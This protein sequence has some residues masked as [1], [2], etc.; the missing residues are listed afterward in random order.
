MERISDASWSSRGGSGFR[1]LM[2][3]KFK[4][5]T[6]IDIGVAGGPTTLCLAVV[7]NDKCLTYEVN[8]DCPK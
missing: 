2:A 4:L 6:E 1:Y 5:R 7:G 3:R 8:P